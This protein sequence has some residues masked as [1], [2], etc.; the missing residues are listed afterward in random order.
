M[1]EKRLEIAQLKFAGDS[2]GEHLCWSCQHETPAN[3]FCMSCE[4][5]QPLPGQIDSFVLFGIQRRLNIDLEDLEARFYELSRAFHPDYFQQK[6][7]NERRLSLE[8]AAAINKGY[9]TLRAPWSRAAY[10]IQIEEGVAAEIKAAAPAE[11]LEAVLEAQDV[12]EALQEGGAS[13][14]QRAE[15]QALRE[16]FAGALQQ[17]IDHLAELAR[18]WDATLD[19]LQLDETQRKGERQAVLVELKK[20]MAQHKYLENVLRDI[21]AELAAAT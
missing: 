16:H 21:D 19:D 4:K 10:L 6:S 14:A 2:P 1:P 8:Y 15:L 13:E 20:S 3:P 11:L 5:L 7:D 18:R 17:A 9:R 12:L